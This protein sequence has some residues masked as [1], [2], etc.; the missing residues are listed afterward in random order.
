MQFMFSFQIHSMGFLWGLKKAQARDFVV[1]FNFSQPFLVLLANTGKTTF[2][3]APFLIL[4][5]LG[6]RCLTKIANAVVT[7]VFIDMIQLLR[8]PNTVYM[9]PRKS[10]RGIQP[11]IQSN[12]DIPMT[13]QATRFAANSTLTTRKTPCERASIWIVIQQNFK[14]RLSNLL[15]LHGSYNITEAAWCQ[16]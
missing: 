7:T 8:R 15:G 14:A 5:V 13:H 3:I 12:S 16:A 4:R 9:E 2:V 6:V 11:I 10:M 1:D